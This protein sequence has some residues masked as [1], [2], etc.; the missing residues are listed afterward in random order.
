MATEAETGG[1]VS[2]DAASSLEAGDGTGLRKNAVGFLSNLTMGVASAAPAYSAALTIGLL[3]A[4]AGMGFQTPAVVILSF[5]PLYLTAA[6][7]RALNSER[8]D[9]GT[10]FAWAARA[11][12]PVTGW[13]G[14]WALL[15]AYSFVLGIGASLAATYFFLL[16]GWDTAAGSIWA[17]TATG[18]AVIGVSLYLCLIGVDISAR[19]QRW[20][21][22]F[23]MAALGIFAIV[24]LAKGITGAEGYVQ[25][26]LSWFSPFAIDSWSTV[27]DGVLL[28][29]FMYWGWETSVA[30]AEES[31][32]ETSGP[33]KA[34]MLSVVG[35]VLTYLVIT[36]AAQSVRGPGFL[37]EHNEDVLSATAGIA[38]GSPLDKLVLFSVCTSAVAASL[39]SML[40][41]SRTAY[42][43]ARANALPGPL[44]KVHPRWRTPWVANVAVAVIGATYFVVLTAVSEDFLTDSVEGVGLLVVFFYAMTAIASAVY[45]R[46]RIGGGLRVAWRY[47]LAPAL[48]GLMLAGVFVKA[49]IDAGQP[50]AG[51]LGTVFGIGTPLVI[52]VGSLIVGLA[53]CLALRAKNPTFFKQPREAAPRGV[54][55]Q[56]P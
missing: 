20:L 56:R 26:Q 3:A 40:T 22:Y 15:L 28:G 23:E 41:T 10:T 12:S 39:T 36:V 16:V 31:E 25:P 33:G 52:A 14:G 8:P 11:L 30:V 46:R 47:V 7:Y 24:A 43:M 6:A 53:L 51:T 21:L 32:H 50:E 2:S 9:C 35:L 34:V 18:V 4:V 5:I 13:L 48:G 1:V 54:P 45:F 37:A 49:A 17:T 55:K 27:I 44:A 29:V 42:S 38:L 19:A